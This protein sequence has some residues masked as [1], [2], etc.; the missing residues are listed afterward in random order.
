M[1]TSIQ[2]GKPGLVPLSL[3]H[4][5]RLPKPPSTAPS[6][7]TDNGLKVVDEAYAAAM[8]L[9]A[10]A[11]AAVDKRGA[12]DDDASRAK[13]W[14][15]TDES[16]TPLIN[17]KWSKRGNAA[18]EVFAD[19][20]CPGLDRDEKSVLVELMFKNMPQDMCMPAL[21]ML[22]LFMRAQLRKCG[23]CGMYRFPHSQCTRCRKY[24]CSLDL[25]GAVCVIDG[26]DGAVEAVPFQA[27]STHKEHCPNGCG[28][29]VAEMEL[30]DFV[31]GSG[32]NYAA[33]QFAA[34]KTLKMYHTMCPRRALPMCSDMSVATF[35]AS[36]ASGGCEHGKDNPDCI[37]RFVHDTYYK[38]YAQSSVIVDKL[39]E[40]VRAHNPGLEQA[41][42]D[43]IANVSSA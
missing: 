41:A 8:A 24:Y 21:Q 18:F 33:T 42:R 36:V 27:T 31:G 43:I 28:A 39:L 1:L 13:R 6:L 35:C 7:P 22:T 17:P 5:M 15:R 40:F 4:T 26:C 19:L 2:E 3:P 38:P 11:S 29:F 37:C 14:R 23:S 9:E 25:P 12:T 20:W 32:V 16:S 10:E 30:P 34:R